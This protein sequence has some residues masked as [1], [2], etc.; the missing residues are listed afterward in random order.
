[1]SKHTAELLWTRQDQ[2]FL[3]HRYSRRHM[4]QFDGGE[5]VPMSSSPSVVLAPMSDPSAVDPEEAFVASLASCHMLWFLD[6]AARQGFRVDS[7]RDAAAGTMGRDERNRV[8]M[9]EVLLR[10]QVDFSGDR[11]PSREQVEQLH[12]DAHAHCFLANSV[13]CDVRCEPMF[14]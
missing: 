7:Y 9:R 13:R 10:P 14:G 11:L 1:M 4:V 5:R 2:L 12:H 3:D 6:M 8:V